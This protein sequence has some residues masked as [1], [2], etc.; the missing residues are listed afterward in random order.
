MCIGQWVYADSNPLVHLE[1]IQKQVCDQFY[2][3]EQQLGLLR[4]PTAYRFPSYLG[5]YS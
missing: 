1:C 4:P 3:F 2:L 5:H